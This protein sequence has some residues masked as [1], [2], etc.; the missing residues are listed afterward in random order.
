M[1]SLASR[2]LL[3]AALWSLV[4]LLAAGIVLS[5]LYRGAVE[6][7]FDERLQVYLKA[8]VAAVSTAP[9]EGDFS[10]GNFGEPRFDLPLSGWYWQI[11]PVGERRGETITSP[12]LFD[13]PLPLLSELGV[14]ET[15]GFTR[16]AY[17]NG[18]G[19]QRLR[20]VERRIDFGFGA[21]Y[22][23]AVAGDADVIE[24][25]FWNFVRTLGIALGVLGIG[26]VASTILQVRWSLSPLKRIGRALAAVRSGEAQRLEGQF[27][28]EISSLVDEV[29][30]LI[31]ANQDV[32]DR[33]RTHV[34]NL[35][36]AL[37]T[38]LS[39][40]TNEAR[41]AE[42]PLAE[43]VEEQAALMR[44]QIQHHLQ[45]ARAAARVAVTTEVTE[46]GPVV[47]GL[48]RTMERI[49]RERSVSISSRLAPSLRFRGERQDLEEM[50]GNL[51]DNACKWASSRVA[52]EVAGE[53]GGSH[54]PRLRIV[55]DDDGPG[56][57]PAQREAAL[58]RGQRLDETKP[59]SGLGL[60]IVADLA[61][62]Y[63]G[64]FDLSASPQGGLRA[65]IELPA[66]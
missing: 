16:E 66:T 30:A 39:V 52:I 27:P 32:V 49:Y 35:A 45:R 12:S 57:G 46:V 10:P 20:M 48:A 54:G 5:Q 47:E 2:L 21:T 11:R 1:R 19:G 43:K 40:I 56:M 9:D 62:L 60:A 8:L 42:G 13:Q 34:G 41:A 31:A 22:A 3:V 29:N 17:V 24:S 25:E 51:V 14:G 4:V 23:M 37:K 15:R 53:P 64:R 38:P 18:P 26:V 59:G 63:G 36:H 65:E 7:S 50:L 28:R 58:K 6:R 44:A 61:G 55:V 33:A